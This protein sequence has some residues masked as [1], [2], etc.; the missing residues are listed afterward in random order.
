MKSSIFTESPFA[1]IGAVTLAITLLLVFSPFY[2]QA[3]RVVAA[4]NNARAIT[5][6]LTSQAV[7]DKV[8]RNFYER[9]GDVQAFA[10][11]QLARQALDSGAA[12]REVQ[13]FVNTM[14]A[15]YVLYDLMMICHLQGKVLVA[16]TTNKK[17]AAIDTHLLFSKNYAN[18]DWFKSCTSETSPEGGAW[19]SDFM[20]HR[21]VARL[22][23]SNGYGM[24]FAAPIRNNEGKLLG[25]W[26]N[27]ASW[28][29]VTQAIR[30]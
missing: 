13:S 30:T 5:A 22:Y 9:F 20:A 19:Y 4:D 15:Y 21:D 25:V 14:T 24:A 18:E 16:N 8:D 2:Y 17:G 12:S 26:Y 6:R 3:F 29:E 7:A 1:K 27:Y 10:Y 23:R 28:A 11:N